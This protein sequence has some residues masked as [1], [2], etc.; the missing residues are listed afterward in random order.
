MGAYFWKIYDLFSQY[1]GRGFIPAKNADFIDFPTSTLPCFF[2]LL[3]SHLASLTIAWELFSTALHI[4]KKTPEGGLPR[5]NSSWIPS[6][7]S[8]ASLHCWVHFYHE[9]GAVIVAFSQKAS[10]WRG[11]FLESIADCAMLYCLTSDLRQLLRGWHYL[12]VEDCAAS[13]RWLNRNSE[14]YFPYREFPLH[15]TD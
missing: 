15:L 7:A 11:V 6:F 10:M 3:I 13:A 1:R 14:P 2:K 5:R 8:R 9:R 12:E 4:R